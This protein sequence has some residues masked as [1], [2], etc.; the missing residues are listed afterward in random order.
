[1]NEPMIVRKE[2]QLNAPPEFVWEML[3]D[4]LMTREWMYRCE[5]L[6][7]FSVGSAIVWKGAEDG[8]IYVKGTIKEIEK[9]VFLSYTVFDPNMGIPDV[10]ENYLRVTYELHPKDNGT[11]LVITQGDFARVANGEKR[12]QDSISGWDYAI[13]GLK[14]IV[15]K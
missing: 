10:P 6:S 13:Q 4:P 5:I 12:Y 14:R 15:E 11:L 1:M 9:N 2:I 7:D 8:R 3:T